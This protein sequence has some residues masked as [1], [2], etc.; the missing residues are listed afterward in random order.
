MTIHVMCKLSQYHRDE[1]CIAVNHMLERRAITAPCRLSV[2]TGDKP[3]SL[4]SVLVSPR[5]SA[6]QRQHSSTQPQLKDLMDCTPTAM[7]HRLLFIL[8][9]GLLFESHMQENVFRPFLC[10]CAHIVF[11]GGN[12]GE[13]SLCLFTFLLIKSIEAA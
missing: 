11:T 9:C 12:G 1:S 7:Q 4:P 3:G 13:D 8:M 2:A 10:I 6:M 5:T